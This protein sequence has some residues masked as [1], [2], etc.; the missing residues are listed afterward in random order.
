MSAVATIAAFGILA[1]L[2][3]AAIVIAM[4]RAAE[5]IDA[6]TRTADDPGR[7][8]RVNPNREPF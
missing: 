3:A 5:R 6:L 1:L 4:G 7:G 2:T 8:I